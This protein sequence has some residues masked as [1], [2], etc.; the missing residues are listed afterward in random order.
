MLIAVLAISFNDEGQVCINTIPDVTKM[1]TDPADPA[2][3]Y[4][5][6][7]HDM[8]LELAGNKIN[9]AIQEHLRRI[10]RA[11]EAPP[12]HTHPSP[13]PTSDN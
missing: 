11:P 1:P 2:W 10:A 13:E 3:R 8:I 7:L 4:L 9:H 6:A 5:T 12:D